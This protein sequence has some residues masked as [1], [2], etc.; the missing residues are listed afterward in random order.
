MKKIIIPVLLIVT[1]F[2]CDENRE[3]YDA[4]G[5]FEAIETIISAEGSG[6][7]REF[8]CREGMQL[9][10]G[11]LLGYIDTTQ[12]QLR[13]EQLLAQI[14][15][16]GSRIPDIPVQ[17][18]V[19]R[20]QLK[21][22]RTRLD[23]LDHEKTRIEKLVRADA[24]TPKQLDDITAQISEAQKQLNVIQQQEA[25]QVSVLKTQTAALR[26][27]VRPLYLQVL[28]IDDQ[29]KRSR[30]VNPAGGV[31]LVK[32]AEK[33]EVAAP[34]KPLYKIA[35]LAELVLRAYFDGSQLGGLRLGQ[36]VDVIISDLK[37]GKNKYPGVVEWISS[38]AEFTPKAILTKE[39]RANQVYAVKIRVK[40]DGAIKLGMMGEVL[41]N[42]Q[43]AENK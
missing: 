5:S 40:N 16:M 25:A 26:S 42:L 13:K 21:V 35:D 2:S 27:D 17:A 9:Q 22:A 23:H 38:Q 11:Q 6:V 30:I 39:E 7:I 3:K 10:P 41:L 33:N 4:T 8:D 24:A 34:G 43:N 15:A 12:L 1:F 20:E 28:Q 37:P 31:V 14:R 32:Y 29:I 18:D 19:F 36:Q